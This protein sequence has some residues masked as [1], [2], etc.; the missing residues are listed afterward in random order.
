LENGHF[1]NFGTSVTL[2]LERVIRHMVMYHSS[3][4]IDKINFVQSGKTFSGRTNRQ[5]LSPALSRST[6]RSQPKTQISAALCGHE[7]REGICFYLFYL[8]CHKTERD[9]LELVNNLKHELTV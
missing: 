8:G 9:I 5:I 7:A 6:R 2:S 1:R 4:S 3:T